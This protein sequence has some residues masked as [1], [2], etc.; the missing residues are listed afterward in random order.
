MKDEKTAPI[1]QK[2]MSGPTRISIHNC[3]NTQII[4]DKMITSRNLLIIGLC[5]IFFSL[6]GCSLENR[7][8]TTLKGDPGEKAKDVLDDFFIK[9]VDK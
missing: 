6:T 7:N 9:P 1:T 4:Q 5:A 3:R 8:K 2:C